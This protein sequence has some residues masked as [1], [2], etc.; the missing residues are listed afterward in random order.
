MKYEELMKISEQLIDVKTDL[1]M[2]NV[3][4]LLIALVGVYVFTRF[5]K[6]AELDAIN[7]NFRTI[8]KQQKVLTKETG[9][10][11]NSLGKEQINYQIKLNAYH[12]KSIES[13]NDIYVKL[14]DLRDA[15]KELSLTQN[16]DVVNNFVTSVSTFRRTLDEKK[17][18]I[19]S[20]LS[21][22]I[23]DVGIEIDNRTSPF[24]RASKQE[25]YIQRMTDKEIEQLIKD[26]EA[27]YDYLQ[28]ES[29]TIFN[30]LVE[31]LS[32]AVGA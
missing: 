3:I 16:D 24:I 25:K 17:I 18:W 1:I 21:G 10:I 2:L 4:V 14:L 19:S 22:Q 7:E 6:T 30:V 8:L 27:F 5:R 15:S 29:E 13:I 26:Q 9:E 32:K 20:E 11:K 28:Q 31:K 23:E 12:E